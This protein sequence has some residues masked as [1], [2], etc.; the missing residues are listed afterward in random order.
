[1]PFINPETCNKNFQISCALLCI[2]LMLSF[3][4]SGKIETATVAYVQRLSTTFFAN[5]EDSSVEFRR[6]F[7][8]GGATSK[9]ASFLVWVE[10]ELKKFCTER[11]ER[12][13]SR[14][15]YFFPRTVIFL[16]VG[17]GWVSLKIIN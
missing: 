10:D 11:I 12:H 15:T 17:M 7:T 3:C 8:P 16:G 1:M 14:T 4:R 5:I 9:A 13:V 2:I 6:A